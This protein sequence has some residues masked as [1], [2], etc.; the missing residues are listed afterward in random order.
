MSAAIN[1]RVRSNLM[2]TKTR[3][4]SKLQAIS[5]EVLL[6]IAYRL[7]ERSP[8]GDPSTWKSGYW[9]K[10]Y[11][12]G[13]FINNWQVGMDAPPTGTIARVDPSGVQSI[14][15]MSKLGRW[16]YGH[17]YYFT[18]NLPYARALEN[19]WSGQAPR[20]MVALT[21]MEFKSIVRE[22]EARLTGVSE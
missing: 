13:H 12:P 16:T 1:A 6:T 11:V 9:P 10:G 14:A 8:V 4:K 18:N 17:T 5:R 21:M 2:A 19:G 20:G 22:A 7:V 15:R 3:V